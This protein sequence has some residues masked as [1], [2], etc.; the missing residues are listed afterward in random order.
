MAHMN[1]GGL[2]ARPAIFEAAIAQHALRALRALDAL[3]RTGDDP[4]LD[5]EP[6]G[7]GWFDSSWELVNGLDVCEGLP[8]DAGLDEW[9]AA[10]LL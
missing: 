1:G 9:L 2:A 3:R 8:S 7:P 5:D 4:A 6:R 10:Y